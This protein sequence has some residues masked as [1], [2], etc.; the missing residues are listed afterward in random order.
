MGGEWRELPTELSAESGATI[1]RTDNG[2]LT[3]HTEN[4]GGDIIGELFRPALG[5]VAEIAP[6]G[7]V[8]RAFPSVAWSG[9][10]VLIAG[11]SNGPGIDHAVVAYS[12]RDR[13]WRALP[14]PPGY[15]PGLS[16][17]RLDSGVWTG[18]QMIFWHEAMALDP[19]TDTWSFIAPFPLADRFDE[20]VTVVD[21]QVVVWG[22]CTQP[23]DFTC[24]GSWLSDAAIYD[25]IGNT[26]S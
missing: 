16:D 15:T 21:G 14:N 4:A 19:T 9:D 13:V 12:P 2:L 25:P 5:Q 6:S 18:S 11:G 3:L 8:W 23:G 17:G 7:E 26:W 22:G 1:V 20:T 10:E 24:D